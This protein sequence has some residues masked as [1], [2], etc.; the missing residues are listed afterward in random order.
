MSV[1]A[2]G[3]FG[4]LF[5]ACADDDARGIRR[6][7]GCTGPIKCGLGECGAVACIEDDA[8]GARSPAVDDEE[9]FS[10]QLR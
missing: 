8:G 9:P 6:D 7:E 5:G 1:L 3:R 10:G 4:P 2:L